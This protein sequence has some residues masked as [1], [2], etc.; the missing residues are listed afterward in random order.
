MTVAERKN[1]MHQMLEALDADGVPGLFPWLQDDVRFRFAGYPAGQGRDNF[2]T[3]WAAMAT[4]VIR[5]HHEILQTWELGQEAI[6]RGEV[7]YELDDGRT[8]RAPFVNVFRL[9]DGRI[10]EY[11]IYVD[12]SA[13]FGAAPG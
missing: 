6:C 3:T 5:L 4:P 12:A 8:V 9:R 7:C 2:A 1:W 10:S 13:V 11:L